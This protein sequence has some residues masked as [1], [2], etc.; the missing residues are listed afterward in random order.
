M[1]LTAGQHEEP[2]HISS[3]VQKVS[4]Q[5]VAFIGTQN[6]AMFLDPGMQHFSVLHHISS[7]YVPRTTLRQNSKKKLTAWI[8]ALAVDI[9]R[10]QIESAARHDPSVTSGHISK[11]W[12]RNG[13][14]GHVASKVG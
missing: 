2:Q 5:H 6:G 1:V 7:G 8:K 3:G 14:F 4:P 11:I 13:R 10:P 12:R 9:S